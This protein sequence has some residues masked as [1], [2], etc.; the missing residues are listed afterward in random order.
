MM[1]D[2]KKYLSYIPGV[3]FWIIITGVIIALTAIKEANSIVNMLLLAILLT[4][5]SIAP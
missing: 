2:F 4:A 3:R 1:E 5:I